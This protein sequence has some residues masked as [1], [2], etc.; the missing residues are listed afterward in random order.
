MNMIETFRA[1]AQVPM[2]AKCASFHQLQMLLLWSGFCLDAILIYSPSVRILFKTCSHAIVD[3]AIVAQEEVVSNEQRRGNLR[4][5][6]SQVW[7]TESYQAQKCKW[8]SFVQE[9]AHNI[10][11][12]YVLCS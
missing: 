8:T 12:I 5:A 6:H 7:P 4:A 3:S 1:A 9:T 11:Y 10:H 2:K